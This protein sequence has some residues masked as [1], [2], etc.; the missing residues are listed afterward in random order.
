MPIDEGAEA[1]VLIGREGS[2]FPTSWAGG[3]LA[4]YEL[5]NVTARDIFTW[6]LADRVATEIVATPSNERGAVFSPDGSL[7]AYVSNESGSDQV[8]VRQYP[9]PGG[10]EVVSTEGGTEPVWHPSGRELFFWSGN[11][12]QAARIRTEPRL[13]A[14]LPQTLFE[15]SYVRAPVDPGRAN[16]DV[17]PDGQSFVMIRPA[18]GSPARL[19]VIENWIEALRSTAAE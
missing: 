18:E 8:Y 10:R 11:R 19:H 14:D 5:G 1:E 15:G 13:A 16:Y 6:S 2:Q 9:G 3:L 7:L 12:L 17:N 4:F